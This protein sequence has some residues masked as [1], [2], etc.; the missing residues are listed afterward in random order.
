MHDVE[1]VV[2][3]LAEVPA[4]DE[5]LQIAMRRR[6]D[7]HVDG[8]R[9]GAAH[10]AHLVLLQ[11][12]QQ[13]HLQTHRH[14]ADLIE[15]QRAAVGRLEQAAVL[16]NRAGEGALHVAEQFAFQQV[17][18]HGAAIDRD[19]RPIAA[20]AGLVNRARQQLF[21]GAA[22]AGD[23]DAG[24]GAG[25]HVSLRQ[26]LFHH[27]AARDDFA[28]PVFGGVGEAGDLQ[29]LLHLVEQLLLVHRLGEERERAAL[30]GLHGVRNRAVRGED[31]H[32]QAR[33]RGSESL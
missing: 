8:V 10:R 12:A 21:A 7:A 9:F 3:I 30:R 33:A 25:D 29:R 20:R 26:A 22:F 5:L 32:A 15:Q 19:E 28:A 11:H 18:G 6:D 2:Q 23:H 16:A 1:A 17:L 13:L 31:D 24:I 27:R 4:H 14:V